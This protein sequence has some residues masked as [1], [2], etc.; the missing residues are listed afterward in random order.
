LKAL[1]GAATRMPNYDPAWPW[2]P[3]EIDFKVRRAFHDG[4]AHPR[5]GQVRHAG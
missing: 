3:E 5:Q 1:L 4:L 2:R